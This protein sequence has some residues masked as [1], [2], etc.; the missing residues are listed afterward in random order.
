MLTGGR[1]AMC[2]CESESVSCPPPIRMRRGG[3]PLRLN[4]GGR[5]LPCFLGR[6]LWRILPG[7]R[8]PA[9]GPPIC[10]LWWRRCV[11]S[12]QSTT[13]PSEGPCSSLGQGWA[14]G[15][16]SRI[17]GFL[18]SLP[19]MPISACTISVVF[20]LYR[21]MRACDG[22]GGGRQRITLDR[23]STPETTWN[24]RAQAAI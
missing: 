11:P 16:G 4:P 14:G 3:P 15:G 19:I 22:M 12:P 10:P 21:N 6:N 1:G 9:V 8:C 24:V 17:A 20:A 13:R 2:V 7:A 23:L 18:H 5:T